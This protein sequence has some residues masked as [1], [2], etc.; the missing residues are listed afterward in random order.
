MALR[1]KS[2]ESLGSNL[3]RRSDKWQLFWRFYSSK[4]VDLRQLR[5]MIKK[6]V[7]NRAKDYPVQGMIPVS[8]EV[9]SSRKLVIEGVSTLLKVFPVMACKFCPEVYIGEEGHLIQT[10]SGYKRRAKNLVHEW[11]VGGLN[12]IIVPVESFHLRH[13][14]QNVISHDQ[15]FDFDRVPAVLELCRQAGADPN[16]ES[17]Y[18]STANSDGNGGDV[19]GL[20]IVSPQ[21][22][23]SLANGTLKA[24]ET[25]RV[26]VQK[27]MLVYPT[28]VC[29][30]CSEVHI[31]PSGHRARNCGVFKYQSWRG[32]HF[33]K[34]AEVDDVVPP[35]IVWRRRP[36]DPPVLLDEGRDFYGHAP[37]VVDLC[38]KAGALVPSK[39]NCMMKIE[40]LS[41]RPDLD[42]LI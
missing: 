29:K 30:Y 20:D 2:W 15:R 18:P 23:R 16:D 7:E 6:R 33:W 42:K 14:Y 34:K 32:T 39:Y 31:G 22:L 24:W 27:L 17:L 37:A 5:S 9:L 19:D 40:G 10:C 4:K 35:K 25:L 8:K 36:H 38:S 11:V 13:M 41:R 3:I 28:K 21:E 26:G 12:D 1:Q